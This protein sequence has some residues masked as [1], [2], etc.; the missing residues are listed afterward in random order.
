MSDQITLRERTKG[1]FLKGE[2]LCQNCKVELNFVDLVT[3][4]WVFD[5]LTV[6][7]K[8]GYPTVIRVFREDDEKTKVCYLRSKRAYDIMRRLKARD[9]QCFIDIVTTGSL[10]GALKEK[11]ELKKETR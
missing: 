11:W 3:D 1:T 9:L 7:P 6:C 2:T 8:C 10:E 4:P 5:F